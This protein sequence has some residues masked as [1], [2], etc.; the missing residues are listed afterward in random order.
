[1]PRLGKGRAVCRPAPSR[2]PQV[3]RD[4]LLDADGKRVQ[5][6]FT[7]VELISRT[8]IGPRNAVR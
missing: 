4:A 3:Q 5:L 7:T 1:M 6:S 2:H 8:A